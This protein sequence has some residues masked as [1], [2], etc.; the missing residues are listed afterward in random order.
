MDEKSLME[1]F[2]TRFEKLYDF[3]FARSMQQYETDGHLVR[4]GRLVLLREPKSRNPSGDALVQGADYYRHFYVNHHKELGHL[5]EGD[6][7]PAFLITYQGTRYFGSSW[8]LP[9]PKQ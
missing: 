7:L 2:N 3:T 4:K 5:P 8:P 1:R 9:S 6:V